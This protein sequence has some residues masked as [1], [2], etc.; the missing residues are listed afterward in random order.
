MTTHADVG[1]WR[2]DGEH[3]E[4]DGRSRRERRRRR[5][6]LPSQVPG[7]HR[8]IVL[9][10]TSEDTTAVDLGSG[11]VVRL[12]VAWGEQREPDLSPFDVV[13]VTWADDPERDDLAQPEAVTA[14]GV[15]SALGAFRGRRVRRV[16]HDVVVPAQ[17]HL[18]GFPGVSAPYWEFHG[19]RPSVA[20]V[21]PSR[22]PVLF[23]RPEDDTVWAR[24]GWARSDNWLPV[25]DRRAIAALQ[26]ARR[27]RL[28]GKDLAAALGFRPQFLVVALSQP[29]D[30]H[31]YKTVTALLPRP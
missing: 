30:G 18:L 19:M 27:D 28:S 23:R 24:F 3:H 9:A 13:D 14:A 7:T 31:C 2:E 29:R 11:A 1:A 8:C 15:P 26:G 25:Q 10:C 6:R 17:H 20:V 4:R 16:L 21:V 22:G 5:R 12:R